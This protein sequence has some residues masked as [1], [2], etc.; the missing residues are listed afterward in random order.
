VAKVAKEAIAI[1]IAKEIIFKFTQL[2]SSNTCFGKADRL[3]R[4]LDLALIR[5]CSISI[6]KLIQTDG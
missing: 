1:P 2:R 4:L 6:I 5:K 3:Y